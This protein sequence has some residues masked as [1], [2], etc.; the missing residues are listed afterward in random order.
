M[1]IV[2]QVKILPGY[3]IDHSFLF[4]ELQFDDFK[5]GYSVGRFW[6]NFLLK[7]FDLTLSEYKVSNPG[8]KSAFST[9]YNFFLKVQL[10]KIRRFTV[11]R[12]VY[13]SLQ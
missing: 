3:R 7:N 1:S 10:M 8:Q 2:S 5:K 4:L 12:D 11:I 9:N 13:T 6:N